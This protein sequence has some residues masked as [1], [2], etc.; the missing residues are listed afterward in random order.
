MEVKLLKK[1]LTKQDYDY[2]NIPSRFREVNKAFIEKVVSNYDEFRE[3][4]GGLLTGKITTVILTGD[5]DYNKSMVGCFILK[6]FR[7]RYYGCLYANQVDLVFAEE[8]DFYDNF[9][10]RDVVFIDGVGSNLVKNE[11]RRD[12]FRGIAVSRLNNFKRS[13]YSLS[14]LS[15]DDFLKNTGMKINDIKVIKV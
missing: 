15:L 3:I 4:V 10:T 1:E 5:N 9:Y 12:M 8:D 13:I 11:F 14:G 7:R 2:M 6:V